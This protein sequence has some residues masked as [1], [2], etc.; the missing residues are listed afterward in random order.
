MLY[1]DYNATTPIKPAVR[2]TV[3]EAMER[4]GNPSSVHR[5]GRVARRD[6]EAARSR[7]AALAGTKAANVVF[8]S[9]GTE[10]NALITRALSTEQTLV[11]SIEHDSMLILGTTARKLPVTAT[12]VLDL[13]QAESMMRDLPSRSLVSVMLVNNETG[14]IQPVEEI[15]KQAKKYGHLV[16]TDATQAAGRIPLD[17][18]HLGVDAMTL[19]AHKIGGPQGVGALI[20]RDSLPFIAVQRGGGQERS[21][22]GGTENVAGIEGFGVAAQLA[23]D[24]LRDAPRFTK[25]R[26]EFEEQLL[27]IAQEQAEIIGA[28]SPRVPQT[29]CVA[30]RG[31]QAEMQVMHFDLAGIAISAGS[32]CSS[33]KVKSSHVIKAM[34][35]ADDLAS[36]AIRISF[37][38]NTRHEEFA[39]VLNAWENLCGCVQREGSSL[40]A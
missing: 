5:Y 38:W 33:G 24:D 15:A 36:S 20:V 21:R 12:G 31:R 6:V 22:R 32:A 28:H 34:G 29:T 27:A 37:G 4:V 35:L 3:L 23:A 9:G 10:A 40:A 11:S 17:F 2:A 25:W 13:D 1:F 7:V 39:D 19:S 26:S 30:L 16:H 8:T 18:D 14:I